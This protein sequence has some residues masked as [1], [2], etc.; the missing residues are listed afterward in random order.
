MEDTMDNEQPKAEGPAVPQQAMRMELHVEWV[1]G[2]VNVS[3]PPNPILALIIIGDA[4]KALA[5]EYT[6]ML[7]EAQ[8]PIIQPG[9]TAVDKRIIDQARG[10][11]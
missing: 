9:L 7:K 1:N 11:G 5:V 2:A 4:M 3:A 10:G 6:K 8:S